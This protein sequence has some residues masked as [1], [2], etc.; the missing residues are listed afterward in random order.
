MIENGQESAQTPRQDTSNVTAPNEK[1]DEP[2]TSIKEERQDSSVT[3][4]AMKPP[5]EKKPRLN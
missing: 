4:P 3:S 1:I 2:M 5:P